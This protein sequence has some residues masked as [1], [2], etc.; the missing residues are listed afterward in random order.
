MEIAVTKISWRINRDLEIATGFSVAFW[1]KMVLERK[2]DVLEVEGRI[3]IADEA[4]RE[5]LNRKTRKALNS[6][7]AL[8]VTA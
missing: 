7:A 8:E 2:I 1:R 3:A 4:L 5:F 6:T